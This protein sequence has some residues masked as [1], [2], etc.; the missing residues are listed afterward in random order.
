[1]CLNKCNL[2]I[3]RRYALV[4]VE[5][6]VDRVYTT[7][8]KKLCTK[9][10]TKLSY[11]YYYSSLAIKPFKFGIGFPHKRCSFCSVQSSCSPTFYTHIPQLQLNIHHPSTL[12]QIFLFFSLLLVCLPLTSL[13]FF[14]IHSYNMPKPFQSTYFNYGYIVWRFKFIIDFLIYFYSP[15][16]I[17]IGWPA[18]FSQDFLSLAIKALSILFIRVRDSAP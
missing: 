12:I 5:L 1:L 13:L 17:F 14:L 6:N 3:V 9:M 11:F 7:I 4:S 18:Y 10:F 16:T 2:V 8:R 15:V